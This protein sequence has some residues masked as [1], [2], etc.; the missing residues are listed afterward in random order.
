MLDSTYLEV[1][2][3]YF[4]TKYIVTC[5][6]NI[7]VD[8]IS[9]SYYLFRSFLNTLCPTHLRFPRLTPYQPIWSSCTLA[10]PHSGRYHKM[11][12]LRAHMG[13]DLQLQ[14][15]HWLYL[16]DRLTFTIVKG[17][18]FT[19]VKGSVYNFV[20]WW[21]AR[22][23]GQACPWFKSIAQKFSSLWKLTIAMGF[24]DWMSQ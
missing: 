7:L 8:L 1:N 3:T 9:Q 22:A 17:F 14:A 16:T 2:D 23:R 18:A 4:K 20:V 6:Q 11:C 21:M 15:D 13:I 10:T 5:P 24:C 19:I 12:T